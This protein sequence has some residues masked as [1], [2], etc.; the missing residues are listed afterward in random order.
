MKT[1]TENL[2]YP[3]GKHTWPE[4]VTDQEL[5]H[6]IRSIAA[7]PDKIQHVT[8][9]LEKI[10]LDTPYRPEGWTVRQVVHHVAD[11]HLNAYVRFKL[12]LTE[13]NPIIK[14]YEEASWAELTDSKL[15]PP[16]ISFPIIR[17]IHTRWVIIM[18]NL[19]PEEWDRVFIHPEHEVPISLRQIAKLY[20]WHGHHHLAHIT[21][22][23][24]RMGW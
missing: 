21:K 1:N 20:E 16:Q 9:R 12:A 6:A 3:I 17:N 23:G 19:K 24:E 4:T 10:Q 5:H 15:L 8:E 2:R 14:T 11:S 18:E 22:L 13:D 7:F